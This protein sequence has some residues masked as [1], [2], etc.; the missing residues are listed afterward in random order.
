AAIDDADVEFLFEIARLRG[1]ER[2]IEDRERRT[3]AARDVAHFG[4]FALADKGAR[5]GGLELLADAFGDFRTGAFSERLEL[6]HRLVGGNL[7]VAAEFDSDEDRA[8]GLIERL[9]IRVSQEIPLEI[10]M[11]SASE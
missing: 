4:A 7:I 11:R 5:V 6:R 10:L 8:L 2:I 1:A 9:T 3:G